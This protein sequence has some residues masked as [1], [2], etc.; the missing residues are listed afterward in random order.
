V[1]S[2]L[3]NP[4]DPLYTL[5]NHTNTAFL[6]SVQY[7]PLQKYTIRNGTKFSRGSEYPT[8]SL[9]WKHGINDFGSYSPGLYHS[10]AIR[11]EAWQNINLGAMSE[12]RWRYRAG[13]Y[14]K[15]TGITFIDFFHFN[16]QPLLVLLNNYEDAFMLP[17]FYS[18]ST[19]E[20][21]SEFHTKYTTPYL[22]LKLLPGLSNSLMRENVSLSFLW[23]RYRYAYTEIG[24]SISEFLFVGELGVYAGFDNFSFRSVGAKITFRFD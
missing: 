8:F 14:L 1:N 17:K 22:L 11:F 15:K 21:Y 9:S 7:T 13:G 20:I 5:R 6:L 23:S 3:Q 24:Y 4:S 18:L 16:E 19:P 2:I 10:D 12:F